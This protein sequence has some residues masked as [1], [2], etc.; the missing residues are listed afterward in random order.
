MSTNHRPPRQSVRPS[1]TPVKRHGATE[2]VG[3]APGF[4]D[5]PMPRSKRNRAALEAA[6]FNANANKNRTPTNG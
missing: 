2:S 1:R 6:V 3:T 4:F 5:P